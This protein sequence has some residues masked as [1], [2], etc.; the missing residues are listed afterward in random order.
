[1]CRTKRVSCAW[2]LPAQPTST[3]V[4]MQPHVGGRVA[5]P[6]PASRARVH[7][8]LCAVLGLTRLGPEPDRPVSVAVAQLVEVA[9]P[10]VQH[11]GYGSLAG[12]ALMVAQLVLLA[13][14][15]TVC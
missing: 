8:G 10:E 3:D 15:A 1:M 6:A 4:L 7:Y 13:P 9:Q 12:R 11:A 14:P 5:Q 2:V